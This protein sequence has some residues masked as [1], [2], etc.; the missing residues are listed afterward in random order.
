MTFDP[1]NN[2]SQRLIFLLFILAYVLLP[3]AVLM[4]L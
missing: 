2:R 4:I 1:W 3:I